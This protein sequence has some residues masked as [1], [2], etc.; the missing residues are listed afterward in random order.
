MRVKL[1]REAR[2][3]DG[4][5][6]TGWTGY[7]TQADAQRLIASGAAELTPLPPEPRDDDAT[8]RQGRPPI[9]RLTADLKAS[10]VR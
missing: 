6:N 5:R 7:L 3:L 10:V 4:W 2:T 1:L 9:K 8:S